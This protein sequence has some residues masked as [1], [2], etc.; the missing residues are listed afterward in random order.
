MK[1][2]TLALRLTFL[3]VFGLVSVVQASTVTLWDVWT[4]GTMKPVSEHAAAR[5]NKWNPGG[6]KV[7]VVHIQNDPFK[8]KLKIAMGAGSPPDIFQSWGGGV[9]K[10]YVDA[11]KVY[12]INKEL[13]EWLK[14]KYMPSAFDPVTFNGKIYGVPAESITGAF[15]WYRKSIFKKYNIEVPKTW[16]EFLNACK[17]L[18]GH[19][20]IPIAL[21]NKTKWP[22]SFYYMYLADRIGGYEF[23]QKVLAH[24]KGY[25]FVSDS[26]I[27]AGKLLQDLVK[28][29]AFEKGFNGLDYDTGQSRAL[30]YTGKSSMI[31]MG[32]W[33]YGAMK[34]EAPKIL[35][36]V[37]IFTF[38]M[39]E[40]GK[41]APSDLIGSPGQDY[42]CISNDSKNKKNAMLFLRNYFT[43]AIA[44]K[45]SV[46]GGNL[47]PFKGLD[48]FITDPIAK[49]Q[50]DLFGRAKH[51]QLWYDQ[52]LPPELGEMHKNVIQAL[53]GLQ[54][55]PKEASKQQQDAFDK[56]Y[57]GK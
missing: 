53:F 34:K 24:E 4:V 41:G 3:M 45:E 42:L 5:F 22:G 55:T 10:A 47:V 17:V 27:K 31:L 26:Y 40:G 33:F 30:F 28:I 12:P 11:G 57:K 49:M 23:V 54:I 46:E 1:K 39:I 2:R 37:G 25:S 52:F 9:L 20:V 44:L 19:G 32:S 6:V 7:K 21:A 13:G 8:T 56:Y 18:K 16:S 51:V 29:G 48:S 14:A 38:P 43:D 50:I 35:D 15:F 36:D